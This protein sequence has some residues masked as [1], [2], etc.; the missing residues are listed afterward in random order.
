M[1]KA[2]STALCLISLLLLC[3]CGTKDQIDMK[4][5]KKTEPVNVGTVVLV[6]EIKDADI[7]ILPMTAKNLKTTLWGTATVRALETGKRAGAPLCEPGPDG[8]YIFR[9]IDSGSF[10]YSANSLVLKDGYTL[11]VK[12]DET[13]RAFLEIA[14]GSGN[15]TET[16]EL[17]SARL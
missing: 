6:N 8:L 13:G 10:Y 16:A 3:S 5:T 9:M 4:I 17:F 1:K 11:T 7:W 14:D 2:I 15:L 12:E